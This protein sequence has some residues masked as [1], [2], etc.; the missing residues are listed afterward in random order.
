MAIPIHFPESLPEA[1]LVLVGAMA[2]RD[3]VAKWCGAFRALSGAS[4]ILFCDNHC[5]DLEA[6]ENRPFPEPGWKA[7]QE[8]YRIRKR[9]TDLAVLVTDGRLGW[10]K[11][12]LFLLAA[13]AKRIWIIHPDG[14]S[15]PWRLRDL[16]VLTSHFRM[17]KRGV[18]PGFSGL[19]EFVVLLET[20]HTG[21]LTL[22]RYVFFRSMGAFRVI[23][24]GVFW[25]FRQKRKLKYS[26]EPCLPEQGVLVER[27][28]DCE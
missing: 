20:M 2:P 5:R 1:P 6:E 3:K 16:S 24:E 22:A 11:H 14:R 7:F 23:V 19:E 10:W 25:S 13:G 15:A 8:L 12:W 17:Q 21:L 18:R 9:R 4:V 27:M 26:S 28:I